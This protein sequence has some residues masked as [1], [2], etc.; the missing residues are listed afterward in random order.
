MIFEHRDYVVKIGSE[1]LPKK[2]RK[3]LKKAAKKSLKQQ[4][5]LLKNAFFAACY[6]GGK[7]K[8]KRR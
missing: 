2:I 6:S 7:I 1:K 5:K 4:E 8:R 3:A